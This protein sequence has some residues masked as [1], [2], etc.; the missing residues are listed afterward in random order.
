ML[1]DQPYYLEINE[2]RWKVLRRMLSA[3]RRAVPI[4]TI[5]DLGCGP[6]WF[7]ARMADI[8]LDVLGLEGRAEL[9]DEARRR[10]PRASFAVFDFDAA[11]LSQAPPA[12]DAVLAFGLLYHLQ[13]PLGALQMFRAVA[14]HALFLESMIIPEPGP[15][16]RLVAE[17]PNETQG[18]RNLALVLTSDAMVHALL[19][20]GF[21]HVYRFVGDVGH[22]D[23]IETEE[24]QKRREI[25]LACDRPIDD[26]ELAAMRPIPLGRYHYGR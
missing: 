3:V 18:I 11:A 14:R 16:A 15:Y 23:F 1:F 12:R 24:Q 17:N 10:V 22:A 19:H 20:V 7:A 2:A 6:G 4:D 9:V 21:Q 13:N 26:S 5:H 25:F 8:G